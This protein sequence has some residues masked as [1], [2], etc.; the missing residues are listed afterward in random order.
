MT[1]QPAAF[2]LNFLA[3]Q[4]PIS[5]TIYMGIPSNPNSYTAADLT[6]MIVG[7]VDKLE[8]D[9]L[10]RTI[11][12]QGRDL[13]SR[14]IDTKTYEKYTNKTASQVAVILAN[15][16]GLGTNRI[17]QTTVPVGTFYQ[18]ENTLMTRGSTEWDLLTFLAQQEDYV[19][20]IEGTD[21]VFKP[22]PTQTSSAPFVL[23]FQPQT[24]TNGSP[25]FP[26]MSL[27][28]SRSLTIAADVI[29]Y[30]RVPVNP[31]TGKATTVQ[32]TRSHAGIQNPPKQ[33]YTYTFPGLNKQQA[34]AR[35][36]QILQDITLHELRLDAV[37]PGE[38]TLKK[39]SLI[40]LKGTNS[41]LDQIYFSD[42]IVRRM[43]VEDGFE[44]NIS[45]KNHSVDSQIVL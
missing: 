29:V 21:L 27:K 18:T 24:L 16:H 40:Q 20:Y 22:R 4:I 35:A 45:A 33:I 7:D 3:S 38:T 31:Q 8:I 28:V 37:I 25:I 2:N 11:T 17:T 41:A 14:L 43:S 23:N 15:E 1:G 6:E 30:V 42:M 5:V 44:Q 39:D 12:M 13:T 10:T 26:G 32:A 34:Q 9:P 36:N 19:T